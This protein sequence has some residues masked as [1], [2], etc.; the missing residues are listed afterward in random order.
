MELLIVFTLRM[1]LES[2][3]TNAQMLSQKIR[4]EVSASA[5]SY[6]VLRDTW[7]LMESAARLAPIL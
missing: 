6:T 5:E 1:K 2:V 4:I 3:A 7:S